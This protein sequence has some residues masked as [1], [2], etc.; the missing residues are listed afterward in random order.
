[1]KLCKKMM[2]YDKTLG[3]FLKDMVFVNTFCIETRYPAIDP[4]V[5][6]KEDAEEC[7]RIVER[8]ITRIDEMISKK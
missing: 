2:A 3:E 5:V 8:V 4:L 6:S 7:F 1:M